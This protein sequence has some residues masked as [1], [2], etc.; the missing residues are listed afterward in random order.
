MCIRDRVILR[1]VGNQHM[2]GL[3]NIAAIRRGLYDDPP[4]YAND[5]IIVGDSPQRRLFRDLVS[6]S[7]VLAAPLIAVLQ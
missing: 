4:V 7:P 6:V 5:V 2:A 3:Y 1:N